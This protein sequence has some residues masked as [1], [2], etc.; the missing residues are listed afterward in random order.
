M[1]EDLK[2]R[3]H[4]FQ[5]Y[6]NVGFSFKSLN[7]KLCVEGRIREGLNFYFIEVI[8]YKTQ[9]ACRILITNQDY[10]QLKKINPLEIGS[11]FYFDRESQKFYYLRRTKTHA[12]QI[13]H[14]NEVEFMMYSSAFNNHLNQNCVVSF[15]HCNFP[16]AGV[17]TLDCCREAFWPDR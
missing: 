7:R 12:G 16:R 10:P 17:K 9:T 14:Q 4:T 15:A 5:R 8:E 1:K 6:G 11:P 3:Y 13:R 2:D